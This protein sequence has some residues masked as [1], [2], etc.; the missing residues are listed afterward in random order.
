MKR[1]TVCWSEIVERMASIEADSEQEV[2]NRFYDGGINGE[3]RSEDFV[4]DSLEIYP[5]EEE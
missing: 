4:E 1:F 3:I 2:E 5:E